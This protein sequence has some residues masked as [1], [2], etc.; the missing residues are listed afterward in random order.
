MSEKII[1]TVVTPTHARFHDICDCVYLAPTCFGIFS[2]FG[3][4]TPKFLKNVQ[5]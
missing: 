2:I 3:D 5:Q 1:K 4:L